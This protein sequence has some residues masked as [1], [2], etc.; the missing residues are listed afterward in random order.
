V[1]EDEA[2]PARI[3]LTLVKP[4]LG[5]FP[6]PTVI[7]GGR[8]QPA[9]WGDGTWQIDAG[10]SVGVY[11]YNRLWRFGAAEIVVDDTSASFRYRAPWSPFGRGR[12]TRV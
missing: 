3:H 2:Q 5:W 11:L 1:P 4:P 12:L 8:G 7:V 6:K 9:Q 10:A